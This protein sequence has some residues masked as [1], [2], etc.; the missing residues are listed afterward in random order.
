MAEP[1]AVILVVEDEESFVEALQV[2]L[3]REG[4]LVTV[5]RDGA[6]ALELFDVVRPDLVLLDLM[7]PKV[8]GVDVCR[9]I[10][11][12][13]DVPIIMVTAKASEIDTVVGLEV[14][15][16]DYVTKPYRL[17]ELVARIRAAL[18][19]A[20]RVSVAATVPGA[21][22][23]GDVS[24]DPER[25][26]VRIRGAEVN[27][28]LKEFE[29]LELLLLNAGRVMTRDVLID[30]VWGPGYVGDTKT[31]DVHIKRLRSKV[32]QEASRP[33]TIITI[34]GLGYKL[35]AG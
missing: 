16:D 25:H 8:S 14:G 4:F 26:E 6:E 33:R 5:A 29:L 23:V 2:G 12:R 28:P 13:S 35:V 3:A 19:R 20:P 10:R 22:E 9:E 24:L 17:R 15:A 32:E 21:I 7:L 30:R 18:R 1:Q 31:L 34:R 11:R 27:L